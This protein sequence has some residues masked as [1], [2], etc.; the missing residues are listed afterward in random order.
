MYSR[1]YALKN[2]K[3]DASGT[4]YL[5]MGSSG[6]KY[7]TPSDDLTLDG[8]H[9]KV[10]DLKSAAYACGAKLNS[11]SEADELVEKLDNL[12]EEYKRM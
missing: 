3:V 12:C 6:A 5:D 1:T 4:Y 10:I 11:F 7:R 8:L 2:N 9:E